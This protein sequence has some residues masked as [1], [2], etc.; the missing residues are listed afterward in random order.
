MTLPT[1]SSKNPKSYFMK[2]TSQILSATSLMPT[3]WPAKTMLKLI[4]RRPM[5]MRPQVVTLRATCRVCGVS[6]ADIP[7]QHGLMKFVVPLPP[8]PAAFPVAAAA[9]FVETLVAVFG[10]IYW[11][12]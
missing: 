9:S 10:S 5:Q 8:V 3:F 2:L 6:E 4:L 1:S 11:V 7:S 12:L